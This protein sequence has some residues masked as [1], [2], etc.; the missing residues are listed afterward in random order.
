MSSVTP[1]HSNAGGTCQPSPPIPSQRDEAASKESLL[2]RYG[3]MR[4][5]R[6]SVPLRRIR[7][8]S[9]EI[10]SRAAFLKQAKVGPT[11]QES[12]QWVR[13][14]IQSLQRE[15][16]GQWPRLQVELKK[17]HKSPSKSL[18]QEIRSLLDC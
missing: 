10:K 12:V 7:H 5:R 6:I 11:S 15:L 2:C 8:L 13:R 4:E 14:Q 17:Q 16:R 18:Q 3:K 1:I 9:V